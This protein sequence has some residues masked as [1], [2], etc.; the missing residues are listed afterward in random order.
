[1]LFYHVENKMDQLERL[2]RKRPDLLL[3]TG[4]SE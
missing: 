3:L 4:D 2:K 1:M